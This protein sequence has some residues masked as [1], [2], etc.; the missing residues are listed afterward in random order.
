M[1]PSQTVKVGRQQDLP[2][3][4]PSTAS[5]C[6]R[7]RHLE[8]RILTVT[9]REERL[10]RRTFTVRDISRTHGNFAEDRTGCSR[11]GL[12]IITARASHHGECA[13]RPRTRAFTDKV[14]ALLRG[15]TREVVVRTG[16]SASECRIRSA[17]PNHHQ[18]M[19]W[20]PNQSTRTSRRTLDLTGKPG[21]LRRSNYTSHRNGM[22]LRRDIG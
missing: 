11:Q 9:D 6:Q 20:R 12:C 14:L 18:D 3:K 2:T 15:T 13:R 8:L 5:E 22:L 4:S 19:V 17:Q 7:S 21:P 1:S 10:Q 16:F